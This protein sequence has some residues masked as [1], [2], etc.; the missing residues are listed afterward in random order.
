MKKKTRIL[1]VEDDPNLSMVLKDYLEMLDYEIFHAKDGADGY[2]VFKSKSLDLIV[3]DVMMPR[4]DGFAL[5]EDIR[6]TNSRVPIIFLTA[7]SLKEDRLK[8]FR[9]GGDDYIT[10]PFSTEELSLRIKAILKRTQV[11]LLDK[12]SE[13]DDHY[14]VGKYSFDYKNMLLKIDETERTLTRKEA[15]LLKLLCIYKNKILP[16]EK[17]LNTIWGENDYFIGRSMDVFIAKLRKYLKDDP[18]ISITNVHG[19]GFKLEVAGEKTEKDNE[20]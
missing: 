10:K 14:K 17:A 12:V 9:I 11:N 15:S 3:L 7:K 5:A 16:R 1:L 19:I 6:K 2:R 4:K 8:G 13:N 18:G 20:E